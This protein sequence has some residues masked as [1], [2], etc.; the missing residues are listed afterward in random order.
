MMAAGP[1][2]TG[3]NRCRSG[4]LKQTNDAGGGVFSIESIVPIM[5]KSFP[6]EQFDR[7][8]FERGICIKKHHTGEWFYAN[9]EDPMFVSDPGTIMASL[10]VRP[11]LA[12]GL[13]DHARVS[14]L[15]PATRGKLLDVYISEMDLPRHLKYL[16]GSMLYQCSSLARFYAEECARFVERC[17]IGIDAD[18]AHTAEKEKRVFIGLA[19]PLYGFETLITKI[20]IGYESIRYPIWE[21]YRSGKDT[22]R[23]FLDTIKRCKFPSAIEKRIKLSTEGCFLPARTYRRC[24]R[25]N[26]DTG[27]SSWCLVE[28][29]FELLWL[30]MAR[31]PDNPDEPSAAA[32]TFDHGLDALTV[33]W[34]YVSEFFSITDIILGEGDLS[35]A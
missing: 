29:K 2:A 10:G 32:F 4:S 27:S 5:A 26:M 34:E 9:S 28:K 20:I 7:V 1:S 30:L 35:S 21:K 12:E 33:A 31:I 15:L 23:N 18:D 17:S 13:N 25:E 3:R 19:E 24:I 22:P 8:T 14:L 16:M 11:V 6:W